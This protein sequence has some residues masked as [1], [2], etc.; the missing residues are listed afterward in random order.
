MGAFAIKLLPLATRLEQQSFQDKGKALGN[1][2]EARFFEICKKYK[3][4]LAALG[5]TK[6]EK[7]G[8]NHDF[9]DGIDAFMT[10]RDSKVISIQIKR[11]EYG[12]RKHMSRPNRRHIPCI[13]VSPYREDDVIFS[14]LTAL[15]A[16]LLK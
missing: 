16:P 2:A 3:E 6:V 10:T 8:E 14:A 15:L 1:E 5:V 7:A 12:K 11:S 4:Q 13:V 9:F